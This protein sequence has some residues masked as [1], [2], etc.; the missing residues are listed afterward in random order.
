MSPNRHI[1]E[2][3]VIRLDLLFLSFFCF[4][5][6]TEILESFILGSHPSREGGVYEKVLLEPYLSLNEKLKKT[7]NLFSFQKKYTNN[8]TF[9]I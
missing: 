8:I 7:V 6:V 9:E 5:I 2:P 1:F 3:K 4:F